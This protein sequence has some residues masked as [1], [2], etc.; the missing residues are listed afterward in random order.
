VPDQ[1]STEE[2]VVL[3]VGAH[4]DDIE[5]ACGGTLVRLARAGVPVHIAILTGGEHGVRGANPVEA[6]ERRTSEAAT[7][8][9]L[10]G[11]VGFHSIGLA[12]L[13][14]VADLPRAR[15]ALVELVRRIRANLLI[16]HPPDDYHPDHRAAAE[17][18]LEVRVSSAVPGVVDEPPLERSPDL[19]FM[20]T[21]LGLEFA[22]QIWIDISDV[23][24]LRR[25]MVAAHESQQTLLHGQDL[26]ATTEAL[27]ALRGAQRG[28]RFAEAFRGC[29][30]W[31][32]PDGGLRRLVALLEGRT[33][34]R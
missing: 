14:V 25:A 21:E 11:A 8:A 33:E 16:T 27:A 2:T 29:G 32:A 1:W 18:A 30:T 28:C 17:L 31:P 6:R 4:P 5:A 10:A 13:D 12:D 3:A 7:A 34:T 9:S 24:E 23:I 26:A 15:T 20:D 22:P 19:V